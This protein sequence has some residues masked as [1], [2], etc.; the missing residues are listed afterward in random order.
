[1]FG[2]DDKE[3]AQ[4]IFCTMVEEP[5]NYSSYFIGYLEFLE[6][7][8]EAEKLCGADF[9]LKEFHDIIMTIGPTPFDILSKYMK[10]AYES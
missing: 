5:A 8:E 3:I 10:I 9:S 7:R 1:M 6:L 4:E 2:F